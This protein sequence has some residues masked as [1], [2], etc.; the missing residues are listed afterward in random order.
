MSPSALSLPQEYEH[1]AAQL[2][3]AR[4]LLAQKVQNLSQTNSKIPLVEKAEKHA[5]LLGALAMNLSR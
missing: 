2:D 4:M 3:G 5:E 1:L